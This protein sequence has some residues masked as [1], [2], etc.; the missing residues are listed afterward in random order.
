MSAVCICIL[1]PQEQDLE[2]IWSTFREVALKSPR[3]LVQMMMMLLKTAMIRAITEESTPLLRHCSLPV[4][5]NFAPEL[6]K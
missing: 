6:E 5:N 3:G 1:H 2:Q 4:L